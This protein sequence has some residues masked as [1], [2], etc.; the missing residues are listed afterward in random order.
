MDK[1]QLKK[2]KLAILI[3]GRGSNME[4]IIRSCQ[5]NH[6]PAQ[7]ALVISNNQEALGLKFAKK[8]GI[9]TMIIDHKKFNNCNNARQAFEEELHKEITKNNID[10]I[11]LAGFM[12]ILSEW[13]INKWPNKIIN[14]HPSLL[15][16]FKGANA[17]EDAYNARSKKYGCSVHYVNK[18]VDSGKIILQSKVAISD[19]DNLELIKSKVLHQE[20]ILYSQAIK[21]ICNE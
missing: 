18:E 8:S 9:N 19:S 11:C 14:I 6:F 17:V 21:L 13:F 10:L 15:P 4:A 20:H 16:S 1:N 7:V 12:R 3:S 2:H 5:E